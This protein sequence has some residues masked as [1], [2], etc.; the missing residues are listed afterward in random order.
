MAKASPCRY[1]RLGW[2]PGNQLSLPTKK[3]H[4]QQF[5]MRLPGV[6]PGAQAWEACTGRIFA[7]DGFLTGTGFVEGAYEKEI[8][9]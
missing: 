8:S 1:A 4:F 5:A 9:F 7:R 3:Q 2:Q 6:E